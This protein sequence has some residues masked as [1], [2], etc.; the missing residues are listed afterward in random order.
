[1]LQRGWAITA[2]ERWRL[3]SGPAVRM[4]I[5]T[6]QQDEIAAVAD[7]LAAVLER[8]PGAFSS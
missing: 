7:D 4:T 5:S 8:R 3:R 6:L 2:G 1:M